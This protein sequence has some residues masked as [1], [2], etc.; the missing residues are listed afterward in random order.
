ML[1]SR[2]QLR[3]KYKKPPKFPLVKIAYLVSISYV[4]KSLNM[5]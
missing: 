5:Q 3:L 4:L 1:D 2:M